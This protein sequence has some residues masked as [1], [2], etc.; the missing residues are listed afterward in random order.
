[1]P[2]IQRRDL[3]A[4][5]TPKGGLALHILSSR[6]SSWKSSTRR[7]LTSVRLVSLFHLGSPESQ[8][9]NSKGLLPR[10]ALTEPGLPRAGSIF[11]LR[12]AAAEAAPGPACAHGKG[13]LGE[14]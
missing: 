6:D 7:G 13:S 14:R 9:H 3:D 2:L 4:L 8:R 5:A 11:L 12:V 1:M 10:E